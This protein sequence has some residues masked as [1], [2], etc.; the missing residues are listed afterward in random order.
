MATV[1]LHLQDLFCK[2]AKFFV[3]ASQVDNQKT[4]EEKPNEFLC[5]KTVLFP[6]LDQLGFEYAISDD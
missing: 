1:S 2:P 5:P 4:L 3:E 6:T